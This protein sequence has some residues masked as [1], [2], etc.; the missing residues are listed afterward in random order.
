MAAE[1]QQLAPNTRSARIRILERFSVEYGHLPYL[2]ADRK[3][4]LK[5]RDS[6]ASTASTRNA[7]VK[8]VRYVYQWAIERQ[9]YGIEA[10]PTRDIKMLLSDNPKGHH[11][12]TIEEIEQFEAAHVL[13][14]KA[15]LALGLFLYAGMPRISDVVMLGRQ[16]ISKDGRIRYT[17][18]K[19][20]LRAPVDIDILVLSE[21]RAIIEAS[22]TGDLTFLVTDFGKSF[23]VNGFGNKMREWCDAAGLK[24]C[25]SHGLRKSAAVRLAEL[26]R[27]DHEIMAMGGWRTLKEVQRYTAGARRNLLADSATKALEADILRTKV[28]NH[29]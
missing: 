10:N 2:G 20:K 29:E 18:T 9:S 26:G 23:T 3:S 5:L 13:G 11:Q 28:S 16:H 8:N 22:P 4:I 6:F 17:Q 12:W 21:L 24:H 25:S 19:N 27:S 7:F 14:T 1:F 15:R